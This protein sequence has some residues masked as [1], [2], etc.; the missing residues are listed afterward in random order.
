MS[1][2]NVYLDLRTNDLDISK[3]TSILP[4]Y[5]LEYIYNVHLL[6]T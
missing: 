2:E 1:Y 6:Y 3:V 5:C 4:Y